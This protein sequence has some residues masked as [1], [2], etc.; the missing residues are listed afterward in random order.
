MYTTML[1]A[2]IVNLARASGDIQAG[3]G[4]DRESR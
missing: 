4:A 1:L 2:E 3:R